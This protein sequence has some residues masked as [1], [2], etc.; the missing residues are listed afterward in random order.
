[1]NLEIHDL[2]LSMAWT[3]VVLD[4]LNGSS[5]NG[6]LRCLSTLT[7]YQVAFDQARMPAGQ[8]T[9]IPDWLGLPWPDDRSGEH[10]FWSKMIDGY[11][12]VAVDGRK[13]SR[14]LLPMQ[15]H[16]P[17]TIQA[18]DWQYVRA[19]A[20]YYPFALSLVVRARS[21]VPGSADAIVRRAYALRHERPVAVT[22]DGG[23]EQTITL[24]EFAEQAHARLSGDY[25]GTAILQ[26]QPADPFTVVTIVDAERSPDGALDAFLP[27]LRSL[28]RWNSASSAQP[29]VE[30]DRLAVEEH[31]VDDEF[32]A[33]GPRSRVIW[34][35]SQFE[36]IA[37]KESR[38]GKR[39][40][41]LT[42][43]SLEV[44]ALGRFMEATAPVTAS[45]SP[46]HRSW[47]TVA[48]RLLGRLYGATSRKTYRSLTVR[49]QFADSEYTE[50]TNAVRA[51]VGE[52]NLTA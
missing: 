42:L 6:P 15:R 48:A 11:K 46:T 32:V 22:W 49:R 2:R 51:W 41:A 27:A 23:Q 5:F 12:D 1:M 50:P 9:Q 3:P 39:H 25:P 26:P 21:A 13:A 36:L 19:S 8:R 24:A 33:A 10:I 18:P 28:T 47:A 43:L 38:L 20:L 16:L 34:F 37:P 31:L 17:V 4:L 14:N 44:D 35:P 52:G 45:A 7:R 30:A 40:T 29:L